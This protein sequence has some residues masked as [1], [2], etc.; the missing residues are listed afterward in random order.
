MKRKFPIDSLSYSK[1]Y[2]LALGL[3]YGDIEIFDIW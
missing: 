2:K 3:E 1:D